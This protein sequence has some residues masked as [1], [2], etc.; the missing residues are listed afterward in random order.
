M[1]N[2]K[3]KDLEETILLIKK[4]QQPNI[5]NNIKY[6]AN[7]DKPFGRISQVYPFTN[8]LIDEYNKLLDLENKK[9][10]TVTASADQAIISMQKGASQIDTFDSNK[11]TYYHMFFK[12]AAIKALPYN[13]FINLYTLNTNTNYDSKYYYKKLRDAITKDDIKNYWDSFFTYSNEYFRY[14]FLGNQCIPETKMQCINYIKDEDNYAKVKS[15]IHE[16]VTFQNLD[17]HSIPYKCDDKYDF[18][19]LSNIMN[20]VDNQAFAEVV[21]KLIDNNL[22]ESGQILANYSWVVKNETK[23][24]T[25]LVDGYQELTDLGCN[26]TIVP[27]YAETI[28]DNF[29]SN[30]PDEKVLI[31]EEN[32]IILCKK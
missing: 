28:V 3:L 1:E 32:S 11:L 20:Y 22:N 30:I 7:P 23:N 4:L 18:I 21:K 17:I 5:N 25:K 8:E 2:R 15:C 31:K 9:V 26:P 19:N 12:L 16:N 24:T 27:I 10:L 29:L 6:W 14:F 13:D